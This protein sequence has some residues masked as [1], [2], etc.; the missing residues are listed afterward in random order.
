LDGIAIA[1]RYLNA[2]AKSAVNRG[3]QMSNPD[4]P[5][6][7]DETGAGRAQPGDVIGVET[8][9][10]RTHLGETR[11]DE[12]ARRE[13]A[14]EGAEEIDDDIDDDDIDDTDGVT[15]DDDGLRLVDPRKPPQPRI[16]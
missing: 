10:E 13:A 7:I 6:E 4:R 14:E 9:G 16:P 8:D 1:L 15:G 5:R 11:E 12:D 2:G 3:G